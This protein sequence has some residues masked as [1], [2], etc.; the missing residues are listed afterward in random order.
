M[1]KD[2]NKNE[3]IDLAEKLRKAQEEADAQ[4]QSARDEDDEISK[5][6]EELEQMNELAKRTMAD[7]QN[8]KRRQDEEREML[9][10]LANIGLIKAILP[11]LDNLHR[12]EAEWTEG[13]KMCVTQLEKTLEDSGLE[14]IQAEGAEFNP[15]LH[16]AL[17]Q[18]PGEMDMVIAVI[19]KGYKVGNRV[20]RHAKVQVGNGE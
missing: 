13:V 6:K 15:E 11:T 4:D 10:K 9:I 8:F 17:I 16:E 3:E 1:T 14:E 7:F 18:V 19:E 12:A 5:L 20:V 2:D